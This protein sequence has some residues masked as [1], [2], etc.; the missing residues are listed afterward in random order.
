MEWREI[1]S[2]GEAWLFKSAQSGKDVTCRRP[3]A[4]RQVT[5]LPDDASPSAGFVCITAD[6][7]STT[8]KKKY[9]DAAK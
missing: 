6:W 4:T 8:A 5:E 2:V 7:S 3:T 1:N 9:A